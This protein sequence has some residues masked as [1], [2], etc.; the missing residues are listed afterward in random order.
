MNSKEKPI[1]LSRHAEIQLQ[2]RGTTKQEIEEAIRK[3]S[4]SMAELGK[5]ECRMDFIFNQ[6]WNGKHYRTKQVRPIFVEEEDE[7]V[8]VTVYVY[9]F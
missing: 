2:Y 9:Y 6:I 8:I 7:L 3:S 4:W 1:R 5:L